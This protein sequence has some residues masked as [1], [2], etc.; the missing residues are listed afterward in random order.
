M[1]KI[2]LHL[3][4]DIGSDS[5]PYQI[6]PAYKVIRIGSDIGVQNFNPPK[7]VRGIIANPVCTEFSIIGYRKERKPDIAKG[8]F[9]VNE[10]LRIIQE[11]NPTW[12]VLENP[13]LGT[14]QRFLG[15]PKA[16]YKPW[17]YGSPWGKYT[18]LWGD[19]N[20]PKPL[21]K[22]WDEVPDRIPELWVRSGRVIPSLGF[23][24]KSK[25]KYI[26]EFSQLPEPTNDSDF[27]SLC[28]QRFAQAFKEINP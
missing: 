7:N 15:K 12:W 9:L 3:C 19:F 17:Q 25:F 23:Q 27:R 16:T 4:A 24:H 13:A 18:A 11:A 5:Y 26:P 10:C 2:I 6:D 28:S 14:L 8:M 22:T 1:Q 21:Y 20:M